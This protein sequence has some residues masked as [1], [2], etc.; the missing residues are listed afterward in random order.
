M[1]TKAT[2]DD[3]VRV[4][5]G[6]SDRRSGLPVTGNFSIADQ[7]ALDA[8][9]ACLESESDTHLRLVNDDALPSLS[10]GYTVAIEVS[11]RFGF[12]LLVDDVGALLHAQ[13]ARVKEPPH[14]LLLKESIANSDA[15]ED[16][17]LL[18]RYRSV[19]EFIKTLKRA[20]AFL[21]PD[22]PALIF[23]TDGKYEVQIDYSEEDLSALSLADLYE[24]LKVIPEGAHEK[25]CCTILADA[26]V[27][28]TQHLPSYSRFRHLLAHLPELKKRF[29]DGYKLFASGFSYEKVRDQVEAARVEYTGKIHKVFSDIQNQLLSI[30]VATIVVATQMKDANAVGYEFW[31][32]TAVLIGCWIFA[33]IMVFLLHNQSLTLGVL[34]VEIDRQKRQINRE[35]ASVAGSFSD[36]FSYLS[37]RAFAQRIIL[38]V[39]DV[40]VVLGLLLS[41][42]AYLKLTPPAREWLVNS[43][44]WL[45]RYF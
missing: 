24:L 19:L 2:W 35:F 42:F 9:K 18:A 32:N 27:S 34:R 23:I 4:V 29:D 43:L 26:V 41:H 8:I 25:Q 1:T 36:T 20:A 15:V 16:D 5:R 7:A 21:D 28:M 22:E 3:L 44:P 31:I 13:Y 40:V 37:R 12:G 6:I 30:P 45:T 11:P 14:F 38:W 39:I 10:I 33:V 17:H